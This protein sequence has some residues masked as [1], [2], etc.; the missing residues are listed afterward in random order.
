MADASHIFLFGLFSL[1]GVEAITIESI[2]VPLVFVLAT[3][4]FAWVASVYYLAPRIETAKEEEGSKQ[5]EN[6]HVN[7]ES[8]YA[9]S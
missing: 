2:T 6:E 7:L 1:L 5:L 4:G 8:S 3:V 9:K